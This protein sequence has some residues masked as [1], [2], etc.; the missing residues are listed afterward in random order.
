MAEEAEEAEK[1]ANPGLEEC[2]LSG[3]RF[4]QSHY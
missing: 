1:A 3:E 2:F 4:R